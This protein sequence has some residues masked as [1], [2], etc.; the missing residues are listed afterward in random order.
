V[1]PSWGFLGVCLVLRAQASAA[2]KPLRVWEWVRGSQ[3]FPSAPLGLF[4]YFL[5][6]TYS[7]VHTLFGSFLPPA[8]LPCTLGFSLCHSVYIPL[9]DAESVLED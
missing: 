7:H 9:T 1:G 2:V 6:F 5:L 8:P 4:I 3:A